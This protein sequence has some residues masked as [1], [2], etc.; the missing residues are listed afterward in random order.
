VS[1]ERLD[2]IKTDVARAEGQAAAEGQRLT[3]QINRDRQIIMQSQEAIAA[4]QQRIAEAS[5]GVARVDGYR[6]A[7]KQILN[8]VANAEQAEK[9]P[10]PATLLRVNGVD[11]KTE[12]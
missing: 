12:G 11:E 4:A 2:K 1:P 5:G 6:D 10:E 7:I 8:E 3:Q 9:V